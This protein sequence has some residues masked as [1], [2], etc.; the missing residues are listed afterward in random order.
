MK[1]VRTPQCERGRTAQKHASTSHNAA[2]DVCTYATEVL[3]NASVVVY[4]MVRRSHND[5]L[6][7][8]ETSDKGGVHP[9]LVD[10][11]ALPTHNGGE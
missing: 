8:A 11:V 2:K 3:V 4:A 6:E 5:P 10:C 1:R 9:E 7:R